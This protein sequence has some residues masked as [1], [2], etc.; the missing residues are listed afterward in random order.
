M[1]EAYVVVAQVVCSL[2]VVAGT[3]VVAAAVL[4]IVEV[5]KLDG[6]DLVDETVDV[7]VFRL[8]LFRK[9]N[10]LHFKR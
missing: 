5:T 3:V 9:K 10:S 4:A 1:D 8:T 2:L 7:V 6:N